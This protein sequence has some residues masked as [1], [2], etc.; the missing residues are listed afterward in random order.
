[1]EGV[2]AGVLGANGARHSRVVE[3]GAGV[4][5]H[6]EGERMAGAQ[7]ARTAEEVAAGVAGFGAGGD[8]SREGG[9]T[10]GGVGVRGG[11]GAGY[12]VSCSA[13]AIGFVRRSGWRDD[14]QKSRSRSSA[15]P[16]MTERKAKATA[17]PSLRS[18]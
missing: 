2:C 15:A 14:R 10:D 7:A 4:R 13:R 1:M 5:G 9:G 17:D 8:V 11:G 16:R 12:A 18:G 6:G 3:Q